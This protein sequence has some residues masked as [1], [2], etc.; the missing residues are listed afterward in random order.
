MGRRRREER[1][2]GGEEG[3]GQKVWI[4]A[5]DGGYIIASLEATSALRRRGANG[6]TAGR[7]AGAGAVGGAERVVVVVEGVGFVPCNT[8][9]HATS[10]KA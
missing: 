4:V 6:R 2:R 10:I 1:T 8:A 3:V 9:C 7:P 5:R